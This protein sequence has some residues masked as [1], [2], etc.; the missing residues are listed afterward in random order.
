MY[1]CKLFVLRKDGPGDLITQQR[2][3]CRKI[4]QSLTQLTD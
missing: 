1:V 3:I 2:L 4:K